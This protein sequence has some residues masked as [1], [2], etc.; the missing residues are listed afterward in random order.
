MSEARPKEVAR[1]EAGLTAGLVGM[2]PLLLAYELAQG[3][4]LS[5]R[6]SSE[7]LATSALDILGPW[8]S[9]TR[10]AL[11]LIVGALAC[12]AC[13]RSGMPLVPLVGRQ[14]VQ[15]G[16]WAMVLG[17]V[18]ILVLVLL[19]HGVAVH[20]SDGALDGLEI[21]G[22][23]SGAAWE[24]LVFRIGAYGVLFLAS[25]R[26][27][28]FAGA[29]ESGARWTAEAVGLVG[30]AALFAA[31]HLELFSAFLGSGGEEFQAVAFTYRFA[32]GILLGLLFRWRGPG[33]CAW[34]HGLFN[35]SLALGLSPAVLVG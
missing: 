32:S 6:N 29:S 1:R 18:L 31:F 20:H 4:G 8:E 3:S 28:L 22:A 24:E 2:M 33:V 10:L 9:A 5:W 11:I 14:L 26:V 27:A 19:D 25:R 21:L 35:L 13:V 16:L 7:V 30:S 17:P 23:V 34:S 15:G 12:G